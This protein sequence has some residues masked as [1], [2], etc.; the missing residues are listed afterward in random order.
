MDKNADFDGP[1]RTFTVNANTHN[2]LAGWLAN[3][4]FTTSEH[5]TVGRALY[6]QP[7]VSQTFAD[8]ATSMTKKIREGANATKVYGIAYREETYIYVTWA[9]LVLPGLVVLMGIVLLAAS[10]VLSRGDKK[11]LWKN[12]MLVPLFTQ[13]RGWEREGLR[14][15]KMERDGRSGEGYEGKTAKG[16]ARRTGFH[17]NLRA[18]HS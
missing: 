8:I 16:W 9:W 7:N 13:M 11:G 2:A 17:E 6:S 10:M 18:C 12:S 15:C 4:F 3:H 5:D 1:N 14:V